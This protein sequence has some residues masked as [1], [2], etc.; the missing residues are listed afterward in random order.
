MECMADMFSLDNDSRE[1]IYT[2]I[3]KGIIK[4]INL[5]IYQTDEP[6]PS[7]GHSHANLV[8]TQTQ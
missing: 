7:A 4:Y 3:E 1:P 2:Q 8:S 6:L 5:E